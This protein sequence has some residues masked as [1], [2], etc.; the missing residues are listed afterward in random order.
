M[1]HDIQKGADEPL[2]WRDPCDIRT[3]I[4]RVG[5][6]IAA[7]H[8][9]YAALE[10]ARDVLTS[11]T[12]EPLTEELLTTLSEAAKQTLGEIDRYG[13]QLQGLQKEMNETLCLLQRM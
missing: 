1:L 8:E 11:Y 2:I 9:R 10:A 5:R 4:N 3:E 6:G 13:E 12:D 7:A